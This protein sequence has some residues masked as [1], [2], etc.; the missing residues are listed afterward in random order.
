M[1]TILGAGGAI[2]TPLAKALRQYTDQVRL[3]SRNPLK[4]DP[5]DE[6]FPADLTNADQTRRAVAG[7]EVAYLTVGLPYKIHVWLN[8]WPIIMENVIQACAEHGTKLVFFDNIY[9]YDPTSLDPIR[10]THPINPISRKGKV[11]EAIARMLLE[12]N[13]MGTVEALIARCADFYGPSIAGNSILTET[14]FKPL[15]AGKRANWLGRADKKHSYTYTPDAAKATA[16]LGNR[17]E[18]YG[19]VWHLPTAPDPYTGREWVERIAAALDVAP[20]YRVASKSLVRTLGLFSS[21]MRET[22]EMLYQYDRDYVFD[23]SKFEKQFGLQPTPYEVGI[24]EV[25]GADFS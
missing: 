13:Q 6:V 21:I 5:S 1:Q 2:G 7:S 23:S 20:K 3:V 24:R 12:E 19:S 9:M 18:A 4:V 14:V 10:E 11:R 17:P 8:Y 15:S 25:I 22:S 16:L